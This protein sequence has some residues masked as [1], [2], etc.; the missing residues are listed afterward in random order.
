MI[1]PIFSYVPDTVLPHRSPPSALLKTNFFTRSTGALFAT[2]GGAPGVT[3]RGF[4]SE[5]RH[6]LRHPT[7]RPR[8][9]APLDGIASILDLFLRLRI[10]QPLPIIGRFGH[11]PWAQ[12]GTG[13]LVVAVPVHKSVETPARA[14]AR[15]FFAACPVPCT[16][17]TNRRGGSRTA[18]TDFPP[19]RPAG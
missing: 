6:R 9:P 11:R 19:C 17:Y 2:L 16:E 3:E 7:L 15:P 14:L 12:D 8:R 13:L 10:I 4:Q 18:P 5:S 1:K